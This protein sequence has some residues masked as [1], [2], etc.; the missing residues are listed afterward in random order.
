MCEWVA[1]GLKLTDTT[2]MPNAQN[3]EKENHIDI[4]R[5]DTQRQLQTCS[6]HCRASMHLLYST[7]IY[8]MVAVC[9]MESVPTEIKTAKNMLVCL[10]QCLL[11]GWIKPYL[12]N[13]ECTNVK[14]KC[15]MLLSPRQ[16]LNRLK[17]KSTRSRLTSNH[18]YNSLKGQGHNLTSK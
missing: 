14:G 6:T 11:S 7:D 17:P 8:N 18:K 13:S 4:H 5:L 1:E 15:T 2:E 16:M 10:V 3:T 12:G 9:W